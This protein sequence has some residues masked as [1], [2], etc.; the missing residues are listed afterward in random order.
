MPRRERIEEIGFYHVINR[1][2]E[3]RDIFISDDDRDKFI[4][5]IDESAQV[6]RFIMHSFCLMDNH[7]HFLLEISNK[8][9]SQLM[10][11]INSKY[12]IFLNKKYDRVGP[13]W[14]GR[15]KSWFVYDDSYLFSII[16]Y[17]EINPVKA[18]ITKKV[19]DFKY[20]SSFFLKKDKHVARMQCLNFNMLINLDK[21]IGLLGGDEN[22][23]NENDDESISEVFQAKFKKEKNDI[24]RVKNR[25]LSDY[26]L[27]NCDKETRNN[28]IIKAV[29]NGYRQ[30][31][32]ANFIGVS[33]VLISK[34]VRHYWIKV[35]LFKK[36]KKKGLF[37]SYSKE[38]SYEELGDNALCEV[39][40][41]YAD[42][43]E[44]II[45]FDVFGLKTMKRVW[46]NKLVADKRFIRLNL[47]IARV[48][49][50]MDIESNYFEEIKSVRAEKLRLLAS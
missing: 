8:N 35:A 29:L 11:Q 33:N 47:F 14:Q 46:I 2:V 27:L 15:F 50:S 12:S 6:Y 31:E 28:N 4:T 23:I 22:I 37:W 1:G 20:A 25:P 10:R 43:D 38:I 3:R 30:S 18:G 49:F 34:I 26:I 41:K 17:I 39:L 48:F 9:L 32:L 7:Y 21:S 19:G 45:A 36:L 16:K 44:L 5:I 13:L 40:L 24:V 42:F